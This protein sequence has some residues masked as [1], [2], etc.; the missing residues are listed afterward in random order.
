MEQK[1]SKVSSLKQKM[2]ESFEQERDRT[3]KENPEL[4]EKYKNMS[5]KEAKSLILGAYLMPRFHRLTKGEQICFT[6][7]IVN[8]TENFKD[9][10]MPFLSELSAKETYRRMHDYHVTPMEEKETSEK[11]RIIDIM[12]DLKFLRDYSK[13]M[14]IK[15]DCKNDDVIIDKFKFCQATSLQFYRPGMNMIDLMM[16]SAISAEMFEHLTCADILFLIHIH[17]KDIKDKEEK[18]LVVE[19]GNQDDENFEDFLNEMNHLDDEAKIKMAE[20]VENV[21][22]PN[23]MRDILAGPN[24]DDVLGRN[25]EE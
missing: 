20:M 11:D 3:L 19:I 10:L 18:F 13:W 24:M 21:L 25:T 23:H 2:Y 6:N 1:N 4:V 17:E 9:D 8:L 12:T 14:N 5:V 16:M 22:D 7:V 15:D